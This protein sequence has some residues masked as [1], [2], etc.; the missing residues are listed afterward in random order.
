ML[1]SDLIGILEFLA[2]LI[3]LPLLSVL[4]C[5]F[6]LALELFVLGIIF[7]F[8]VWRI[9][10]EMIDMNRKID[11]LAQPPQKESKKEPDHKPDQE[12]MKVS[13]NES[14]NEPEA[15]SEKVL[16]KK[17]YRYKWK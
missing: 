13:D 6:I 8:A 5:F 15:H 12:L 4:I 2:N 3:G 1:I 11:L 7:L 14:D 9:R 10:K 16:K 17:R